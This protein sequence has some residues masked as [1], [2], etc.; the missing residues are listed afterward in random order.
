M[1]PPPYGQPAYG[2]PPQPAPYGQPQPCG[3]QP[4]AQPYTQPY[5]QPYAQPYGQPAYGAPSGGG[6]LSGV[7]PGLAAGGGVLAGL[8]GGMLLAEA[9]DGP[10]V[11]VY[12]GW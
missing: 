12:D 6:F 4:Y 1:Q 10:D 3:A 2:Q 5:A 11:V 7:S 9:F 8:A